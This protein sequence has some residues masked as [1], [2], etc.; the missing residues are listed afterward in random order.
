VL[1]TEVRSLIQSARHAA[2]TTVNTLQVLTNF[3]LDRRHYCSPLFTQIICNSTT[4]HSGTL[5]LL[6]L[7]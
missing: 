1:I 6:D 7:S 2:V 5:L 4:D 3:K